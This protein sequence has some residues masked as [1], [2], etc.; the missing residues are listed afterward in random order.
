MDKKY[1]LGIPQIDKQHKK[2]FDIVDRAKLSQNDTEMSEITLELINY[3]REHL[4]EEETLIKSYDLPTDYCQKH[5]KKHNLF[6]VKAIDLYDDLRACNNPEGKKAIINSI[7]HFCEVWIAEHIDIE[8]R[9][10]AKLF[11]TKT[12][13]G[14]N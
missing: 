3:I 12:A 1:E 6:R 2:I 10:Y 4:D 11:F 14:V 9:E 5:F 7:I 8:D 13:P